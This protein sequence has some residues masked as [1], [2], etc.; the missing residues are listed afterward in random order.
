MSHATLAEMCRARESGGILTLE[1]GKPVIWDG[2]RTLRPTKKRW[3]V[4]LVRRGFVRWGYFPLPR[5]GRAGG[6]RDRENV[7]RFLRRLER[8]GASVTLVRGGIVR[9]YRFEGER[10]AA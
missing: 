10:S 1:G 7:E 8:A 4:D 2:E 3:A 9:V 6:Q 5:D